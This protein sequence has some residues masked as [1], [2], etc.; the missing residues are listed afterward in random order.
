MCRRE[1]LPKR[2]WR[3]KGGF[4]FF[5]SAIE[6]N[7]GELGLYYCPRPR[8]YDGPLPTIAEIP[9]DGISRVHIY[10]IQGYGHSGMVEID[11]LGMPDSLPFVHI[12]AQRRLICTSCVMPDW[13]PVPGGAHPME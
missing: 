2:G 4:L 6:E 5:S 11:R 13:P 10:C 9:A 7:Q 12:P 3:S 8:T 1:Y